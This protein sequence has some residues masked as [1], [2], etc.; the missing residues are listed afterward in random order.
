[1]ILISITFDYHIDFLTKGKFRFHNVIHLY[2]GVNDKNRDSK[3]VIRQKYFIEKNLKTEF[4]IYLFFVYFHHLY[5]FI[6]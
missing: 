3:E 6:F 5:F 2:R 1:M 4:F